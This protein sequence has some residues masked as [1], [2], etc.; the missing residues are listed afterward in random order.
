VAYKEDLQII[1]DT[2]QLQ[3]PPSSPGVSA[4]QSRVR[5][6]EEESGIFSD[7]PSNREVSTTLKIVLVLVVLMT[8]C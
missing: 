2:F 4:K 3:L 1:S 8:C 7:L 6:R 5:Q